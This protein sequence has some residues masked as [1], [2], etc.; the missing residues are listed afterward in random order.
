MLQHHSPPGAVR[1]AP[2]LAAAEQEE[3]GQPA[4][5]RMLRRHMSPEPRQSMAEAPWLHSTLPKVALFLCAI[6]QSSNV[7]TTF[8]NSINM[9]YW[10][11]SVCSAREKK[12]KVVI[13]RF[14]KGRSYMT[15]DVCTLRDKARP[16]P[17]APS[18]LSQKRWISSECRDFMCDKNSI[19]QRDF[20]QRHR[21]KLFKLKMRHL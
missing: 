5:P 1:S 9:T 14:R 16:F 17:Q 19:S 13:N 20:I 11:P 12:L 3:H 7:L 8:V 15:N 6:F 4:W 10:K 18:T 2:R 21:S